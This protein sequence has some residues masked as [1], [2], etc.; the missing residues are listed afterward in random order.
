MVIGG[1]KSVQIGSSPT[2]SGT[3]TAGAI[4][5]DNN[6]GPVVQANGHAFNTGIGFN[7]GDGAVI[8]YAAGIEVGKSTGSGGFTTNYAYTSL[9]GSGSVGLQLST[10]GARLKFSSGGTTDY[11]AG[12]GSATITAAGTLAA[13]GTQAFNITANGGR[14]TWTTAGRY[15]SV[16]ES[17]GSLVFNSLSPSGGTV[18]LEILGDTTS[19]ARAAFRIVPQDAQPTGASTIGDMY[20][21]SAGILKICT[22]AGTPGTWVNVGSQ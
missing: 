9:A 18:P 17:L 19:P 4:R 15:L 13:A 20:V 10:A 14:I 6:A 2:I 1:L 22:V 11:L 16:D 8:F 7:S 12:D 3:I 5:L 21:T